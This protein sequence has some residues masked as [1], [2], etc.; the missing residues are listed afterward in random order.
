MSTLAVSPGSRVVP[1]RRAPDARAGRPCAGSARVVPIPARS[2]AVR[3]SD[4][5]RP[6]PLLRA[7]ADGDDDG[8]V[9][10]TP[11]TD[12]NVD[13]R[14][15][16]VGASEDADAADAPVNLVDEFKRGVAF[17]TSMKERFTQ[18]RIDDRGLPIADALV[19]TTVP[20]FVATVVLALGIPRPSWLVPAPWVPRWRLASVRRARAVPWRETRRGL[21][22]GRARREGVRTRGV[23]RNGGRGGATDGEGRVFRRGGVGA[24]HAGEP[25]V[26]IRGDGD[27]AAATRRFARDGSRAQRR[28]V[29][30]HRGRRVRG[31]GAHRVANRAM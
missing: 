2:P 6:V 13:A 24:S 12:G 21:D 10:S 4:G 22:P 31:G 18:A 29:R 23:R 19:V 27:G 5:R 1:G 26:E 30:T 17:G 25:D 28:G 20:V 8:P 7:R 11:P 14:N 15:P 9:A 16:R 3:R